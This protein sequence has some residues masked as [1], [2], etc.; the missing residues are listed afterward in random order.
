M[1]E[2]NKTAEAVIDNAEDN[3]D[4][5][6]E[7]TKV[8]DTEVKT[9]DVVD[10]NAGEDTVPSANTDD[11]K[12]PWFQERINSLAYDKNQ[13]LATA[14]DLRLK[15]QELTAE[16]AAA[17]VSGDPTNIAAAQTEIDKLAN[18]KANILAKEIAALEIHNKTAN[19]I[20]DAGV[21][22]YKDFS[23]R[24][25]DLRN[26]LGDQ[27]Y[28]NTLPIMF[29]ALDSTDT[30]KVMYYLSQNPQDAVRIAALDPIKQAREYVKLETKISNTKEATVKTISD[31]PPPITT[32]HGK[33]P[34][35]PKFDESD[36]KTTSMDEWVKQRNAH[37]KANGK[38][39]WQ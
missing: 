9:D 38:K 18:I 26:N 34:A 36:T 10:D 22:E 8:N 5:K 37:L 21:K 13:A 32:V 3:K 11:K 29:Q 17:K 39:P 2:E 23:N 27:A 33:K 1:T 12:L 7:D 16:L 20:Y 30:H 28:N 25:T 15:N 31:A 6:V 4:V 35:A 24:V 19:S 14:E